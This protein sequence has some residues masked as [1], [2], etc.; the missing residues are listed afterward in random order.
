MR[1]KV[2][3]RGVSDADILST[4]HLTGLRSRPCRVGCVP[5]GGCAPC[6][7]LLSRAVLADLQAIITALCST[8]EVLWIGTE[9]KGLWRLDLSADPTKPGSR[10]SLCL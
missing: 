3:T 1:G 2:G 6:G 7:G 5:H 4:E 8:G 9:D 10:R